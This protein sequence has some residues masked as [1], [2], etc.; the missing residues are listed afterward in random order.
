MP[1]SSGL[2][3]LVSCAL[4]L[5]ARGQE[6]L[7]SKE[8]WRDASLRTL[9]SKST[10]VALE[11]SGGYRIKIRLLPEFSA[12]SSAFM[13]FAAQAQ[14][15][16]SIYR[17]E[18]AFLIEGEMQCGD[19]GGGGEGGGSEAAPQGAP[20]VTPGPCPLG[21][22]ENAGKGCH[23]PTLRRGMVAWANG[24]TGPT[25]FIYLGNRP[26]SNWAHEHTVIGEVADRTSF[27]ALEYVQKLKVV[28]PPHRGKPTMLKKPLPFRVA[29]DT[30]PALRGGPR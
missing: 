20:N 5:G 27:R 1:L 6:G 7:P 29:E 25:F 10:F 19:G 9:A 12:E 13:R 8:D 2:L 11:V 28:P 26:A 14:C 18:K 16:G 4:L 24:K 15:A 3:R 21:V 22:T 17:S 23:G 30:A